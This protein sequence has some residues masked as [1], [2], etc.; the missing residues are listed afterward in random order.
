MKNRASGE[1]K[2]NFLLLFF[3]FDELSTRALVSI[4]SRLGDGA[5]D[6]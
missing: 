2:A 1:E 3:T 4:A 5:R 6:R